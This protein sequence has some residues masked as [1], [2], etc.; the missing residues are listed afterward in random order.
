MQ[1]IFFI[2]IAAILCCS[3]CAKP[4]RL[5]PE[6]EYRKR[7]E[8]RMREYQRQRD[9]ITSLSG[10]N[11][12]ELDAIEQSKKQNDL[13]PEPGAFVYSVKSKNLH[14]TDKFINELN[15]DGQKRSKEYRKSVR[16]KQKSG[17]NWVY[18]F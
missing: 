4:K 11:D 14:S 15:D 17:K 6:E 12:V 10:L 18:G 8:R 5:T 9:K 3:G 2:I 13:N 16:Q 7:Q 1:K